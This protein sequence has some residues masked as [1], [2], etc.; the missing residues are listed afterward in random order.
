[1]A[2]RKKTADLD[3]GPKCG[4]CGRGRKEGTGWTREDHQWYGVRFWHEECPDRVCL[5]PVN[6]HRGLRIA[7]YRPCSR[8]GKHQDDTGKWLC[9]RHMAAHRKVKENDAKRHAEN[10]A[11]A[12]NRSRSD[13]AVD[14]L[15]ELGVTARPSY[16]TFNHRYTGDVTVDPAELFHVLGIGVRLPDKQ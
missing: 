12:S 4:R 9:G 13:M 8:D 7:K 1:M 11:S 16:D 6:I 10:N 5:T 14:I 2:D 15:K 3:R